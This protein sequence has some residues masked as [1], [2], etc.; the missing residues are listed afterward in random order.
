M[1]TISMKHLTIMITA[2]F[3]LVGCTQTTPSMMNT[4]PMQ[5]SHETVVEQIPV[6]Q[7]ND[8]VISAIAAQYLKNAGENPLDLTMTYDPKSKSFTAM[9]ALHELGRVKTALKSKGVTNVTTQTLAVPQGKASL[10]VSYDIIN[11]HA[12]A[13]C[14]PMPGLEHNETG[15]FIGEYKFGCGVDTM[16]A[17]QIANPKDL[18]GNAG[19]ATRDARRESIVVEDYGT[20]QPRTP[21]DGVERSDLSVE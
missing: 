21:L 4:S 10:M 3:L 2:S 6:N 13:D 17:R 8:D 20:A 15:R 1:M 11:V 14:M 5:L 18:E 12:A 9:K 7:L 16:L 19:L